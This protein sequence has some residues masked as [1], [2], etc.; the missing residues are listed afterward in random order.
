[1]TSTFARAR[2]LLA[3]VSTRDRVVDSAPRW[4]RNGNLAR[5]CLHY[6]GD[7]PV[8]P[9]DWV[10]ETNACV[11]MALIFSAMAGKDGLGLLVLPALFDFV[12]VLLACREFCVVDVRGL[13]RLRYD[14]KGA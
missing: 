10:V 5:L 11:A 9:C 3:K 12:I 13:E 1:M 4:D 14:Y 2:H 7:V 6:F 8:A